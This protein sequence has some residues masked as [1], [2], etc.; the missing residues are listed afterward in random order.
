MRKALDALYGAALFGACLSMV[1]IAVLV[2]IQVIGRI[3]DR[4]ADIFGMARIGLAVPSI[5]EIGG[6]L[7]IC[8]AFLALPATLRAAGHVRVTIA[9]RFA[10]EKSGRVLTA[11]VLI[12]ALGLAAFA[13]WTV[14]MQTYESFVRGS[15]SYGIVP[16]PLFIPQ[17][18]MTAGLVIFTVAILDEL[19]MLLSGHEPAFRHIERTR[20]I[21]EGGH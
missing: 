19:V 16:I 4:I 14:G 11:F 13:S 2:L 21:S 10:G 6:F 20:E 17:L 3:I 15:L 18:V 12:V 7:F 8:A 9:L 5:A 1:A